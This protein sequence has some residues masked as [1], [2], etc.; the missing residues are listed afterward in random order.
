[1][2]VKQMALGLFLFASPM[3]AQAGWRDGPHH[4]GPREAP[5][6]P[7][8][9]RAA[10]RPGYVWSGGHHEWRHGHYV[11]VSGRLMRERRGRDWDDGRWERHDDHYDWH[12]GG[13]RRHR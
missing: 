3:V 9:E 5:P 4:A 2:R 11:W 13:W 12:A 6:P 8:E 1:M 10:S 7:I